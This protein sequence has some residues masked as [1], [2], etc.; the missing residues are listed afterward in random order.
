MRTLLFCL[1][2]ISSTLFAQQQ[3][4]WTN[5]NSGTS[6]KINDVYFHTPDTGYIVGENY[7]FKK[8]TDGGLT[9][10]DLPAP[11]SGERPGNNG[12]IVAIA[13]HRSFSSLNTGLYLSWEKAYHGLSTSDDGQTYQRFA[14]LDSNSF[15]QVNGFEVLPANKGNSY[16]NVITFGKACGNGAVF[17]N[18]YD[19]PFS[20]VQADTTFLSDP[21]GFSS[22]DVDSF[23]LIIGHQNGYLLRYASPFISPDTFFTDTSG[24]GA[25]AYAGNNTWYA[26]T[27]DN[28]YSMYVSRDSGRSFGIDSAFPAT[29]FY[30]KLRDMDFLPSGLGLGG[31]HSNGNYGVIVVKESNTWGFYPTAH[32]INAVQIMTDGTSY[33]VGD[34][35]TVMKSTIITSLHEV[36]QPGTRWQVYPNPTEGMIYLEG[37]GNLEPELIQ[38]CDLNGRELHRFSSTQRALNLSEYS[39]GVYLIRLVIDKEQLL[40]K[41]IIL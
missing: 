7:L 33:A 1:L 29:F 8:T 41:V 20:V 34:S 12:N 10:V 16:V 19:G 5:L 23:A 35:G 18:F 6:K 2:L 24:V 36:Q 13:Y 32:P 21:G 15:C 9:W 3:I 25:L 17:E 11:S 39:R 38:L 4:N 27:D 40:K 30:P 14:Y 37:L 22:A 31:G 26:A 28:Y